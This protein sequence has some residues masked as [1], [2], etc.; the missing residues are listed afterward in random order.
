VKEWNK[1]E[2]EGGVLCQ[3]KKNADKMKEQIINVL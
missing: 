3:L 2:E 1:E